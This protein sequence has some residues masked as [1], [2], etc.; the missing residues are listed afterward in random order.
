MKISK[1]HITAFGGLKEREIEFRDGF[2]VVIGENENGKS[3]AMN[4]IKMMFYGNERGSSQVAKNPRKKYMPWDGAPMAGSVEFEH[5]GRRYRL[6]REFKNSNATD[7]LTLCDLDFGTR[8]A[9]TGKIG[10]KFFG[11][12]A[13]AFERS[14]FIGQTGGMEENPEADGE[15]NSKLANMIT[16]GEESV[17]YATV[18]KRLEDAHRTL[19]SKNGKSGEYDKTVA[20]IAA[21]KERLL[22]AESFLQTY[23]SGKKQRA[24][25]AEE[26]DRKIVRAR[27]LKQRIESEQAV[28]D[29]VKLRE[30]LELK[31]K[32]DKQNETLA[33]S[34]GGVIDE[35]FVKTVGFGIG[36]AE[37]A[38]EKVRGKTEE[39]ERLKES[40]RLAENPGEE[41]SPEKAAAL[42]RALAEMEN[43]REETARQLREEQKA[44]EAVTAAPNGGKGGA[45]AGLWITAAAASVAAVVLF[46]LHW[47]VP[48]GIAAGCALVAALIA[49]VLRGKA[50]KADAE[51]AKQAAALKTRIAA[52]Q[53][54]D[55]KILQ[56]LTAARTKL[57]AIEAALG[58]NSALLDRQKEL[59]AA[60]MAE[61]EQLQNT[62]QTEEE[63][64]FSLFGRY[65]R[66]TDIQEI[67]DSLEPLSAA[68]EEQ[69]E[70]KNRLRYV[71]RD[72]GNPSYEEAEQ[73]LRMTGGAVSEETDFEAV[74][75]EYETLLEEIS[76]KKAALAEARANA[77]AARS[78]ADDPE[79][80]KTEIE[81]NRARAASQE[82]F[83]RAAV[84]A[85]EV[86]TDSF[87]TLRRSY[88]SALEKKAAAYFTALTGGKYS[89]MQISRAFDISVEPEGIFGGKEAAY[90]SSGAEDQAY[91]SLRLAL[92][93]LIFENT[94]HLPILLD[95][96]LCRY[97]DK[98]TET[99]LDFFA[100]LA[101]KEQVI[102]FTC[103][104][105]TADLACEKGAKRVVL[106]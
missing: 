83:C 89:G 21:L 74:K 45:I 92:S 53:E 82:A 58:S 40:I 102:L 24:A 69:K 29:A 85:D 65:R 1:L 99:A 50:R 6:E 47:F 96:V 41:V 70:L 81:E 76:E 54:E 25:A 77:E 88:G 39:A 15:I 17:S 7:K 48:G 14:V 4:F 34:D 3:T 94:E 90:L 18:H 23:E 63:K 55:N 68:V 59:L 27:E 61:M 62:Y 16:T 86:L 20:R 93:E 11:L 2:N 95:D 22:A 75:R 106:T 101:K 71:A 72:L 60:C 26:I 49:A 9:V 64:V 46:V 37:A 105:A 31:T 56:D 79:K 28:R 57:S 103:R 13:A 67:K 80:L 51:A 44:L 100:E 32:L 98:R 104:N 12:S 73:K 43:R 33:F 87:A 19:Q 66:V 91:L 38:A 5:N 35:V 52:R 30:L 36:K 8:Q 42:T 78:R 84:L 10:M 97:D